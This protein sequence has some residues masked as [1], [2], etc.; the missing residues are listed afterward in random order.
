ML[1]STNLSSGM[2]TDGKEVS[3]SNQEEVEKYNTL[4]YMYV[5]EFASLLV[6]YTD[7]QEL[8]VQQENL[9]NPPT[10]ESK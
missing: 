10:G 5:E 4:V 9:N 6:Q 2:K 7:A 1:V 3:E 8:K